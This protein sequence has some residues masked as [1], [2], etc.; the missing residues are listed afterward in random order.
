MEKY[1][2]IVKWNG[3]HY[4]SGEEVIGS[5]IKFEN[6]KMYFVHCSPSVDGVGI[7]APGYFTKFYT[8]NGISK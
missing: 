1:K 6:G 2:G 5:K 3:N 7:N 8:P 4:E